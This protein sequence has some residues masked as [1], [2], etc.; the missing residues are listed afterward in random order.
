MDLKLE[1]VDGGTGRQNSEMLIITEGADDA[2]FINE[3]LKSEQADAQKIGVCFV[4]GHTKIAGFAGSISK[5][6]D[7]TQ[8]KIER[9]AFVRDADANPTATTTECGAYF[10]EF[11]V[12]APPVG[13]CSTHDNRTFGLFLFPGGGQIGCL[14]DLL[15]Q[16]P[17]HLNSLVSAEGFI[18]AASAQHGN[19]DSRSKRVVQ[20]YLA[21]VPSKLC[22]GVGRGVRN[23]D[24]DVSSPTLA[25]FKSFIRTFVG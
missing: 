22:T 1:F 17:T 10:R 24:F 16:A 25:P 19:L 12:Q 15:I 9:I 2:Y 13:S 18:Q 3:V 6:P 7:Y 14:E 8:N 23:G 21:S 5:S 4:G 20:S 11:G